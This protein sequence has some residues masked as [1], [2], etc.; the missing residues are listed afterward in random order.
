M[1][2]TLICNCSTHLRVVGFVFEVFSSSDLFIQ[3]WA[4][5][6]HVFRC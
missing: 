1:M 2:L 6:I 3:L 4:F 5:L